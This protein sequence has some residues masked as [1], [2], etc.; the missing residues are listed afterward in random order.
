MNP[1]AIS[2]GRCSRSGFASGTCAGMIW[3]DPSEVLPRP[4]TEGHLCSM[5]TLFAI[6][7]CSGQIAGIRAAQA[8]T[9]LLNKQLGAELPDHLSGDASRITTGPS[10]SDR[11]VD[12]SKQM[13][14]R[15]GKRLVLTKAA[16]S[17]F[18]RRGEGVASL[19]GSPSPTSSSSASGSAFDA[20]NNG[21]EQM[22][23]PSVICALLSLE[24]HL[25]AA[26]SEQT[27]SADAHQSASGKGV[28]DP[29][30]GGNAEFSA[31]ESVFFD[32]DSGACLRLD[33]WLC[34]FGPEPS[35]QAS[36]SS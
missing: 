11:P 1:L 35:L 2:T 17:P 5:R 6:A 13:E 10:S 25:T 8:V 33:C 7:C 30:I 9:N 4:L 20:R 15:D 3:L 18:L 21:Q 26:S 24:L 12:E 16:I 14:R 19:Q 34:P 32:S 29:H 27:A 31:A 22:R 36:P 28:S 23:A